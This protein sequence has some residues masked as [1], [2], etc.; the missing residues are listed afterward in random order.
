MSVAR[1]ERPAGALTVAGGALCAVAVSVAALQVVAQRPAALLPLVGLVAAGAAILRSPGWLAPAFLALTWTALGD[2][3]F[4]GLPSPITVGALVMLGVAMWRALQQP[5]QARLPLAIAVLLLV[6]LVASAL[7]S[8]EALSE[9]S[10]P[11]REISFLLI[12][13]LCVRDVADVRRATVALSAIGVILGAGAIWSVV[14]GPFGVFS[15]IDEGGVVRAQGPFG[16]PN[17]FALSLAALLPFGLLQVAAGGWRRV[18]GLAT[19][20]AVVGGVIAT[21]S[22]GGLVACAVGLV[23]FALLA[24]GRMRLFVIGVLA[25]GACVAVPVVT[26][27]LDD[28]GGRTVEGR[29]TENLI[30]LH[31]FADH[32]VAGVGPGQYAILYRD[33]SRHIGDDTR[34]LRAAHSL[35]LEIAAEQGLAGLLAWLT[36]AA[37]L[38]ATIVRARIFD[39]L[40]GRTLVVAIVTY[41]GGSLFLHG[42]QLR[43]LFILVGLVL[44][45]AVAKGRALQ[46]GAR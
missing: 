42:S 32:P 45:L 6:P 25:V 19:M 36:V 20:A 17:F 3:A 31:M 30:A 11:L 40:M 28:A 1:A 26:S 4:G 39:S 9:L 18:L 2:G 29:A 21:N 37:V 41:L 35:P 13:A 43:L 14:H 38:I 33:Y 15:V 23:A 5:A 27:Q 34:S 8:G 12:A 46:E 24:P 44:A 7:L 16:E 10:G 22:R